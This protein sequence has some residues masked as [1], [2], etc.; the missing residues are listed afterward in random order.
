MWCGLNPR[1]LILRERYLPDQ[2]AVLIEVLFGPSLIAKDFISAY[3]Y[4]VPKYE[5]AFTLLQ[6][7]EKLLRQAVLEFKGFRDNFYD[8][9][10]NGDMEV[11]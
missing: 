10:E 6:K 1:D 11:E 5:P 2:D 3:D 8:R 7:R 9:L 4:A